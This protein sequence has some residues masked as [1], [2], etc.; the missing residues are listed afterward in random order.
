MSMHAASKKLEAAFSE[1]EAKL[2]NVSAKADEAILQSSKGKGPSHLVKNLAEIKA[3]YKSIAEEV[4]ALKQTQATFVEDI[5]KELN[6]V[7]QAADDLN[8]KTQDAKK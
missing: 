2:D 7:C 6:Q 8:T 5:L 3:E 1:A 4:E